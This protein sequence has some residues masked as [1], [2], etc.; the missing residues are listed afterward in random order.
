LIR[1]APLKS[2]DKPFAEEV[3][4]QIRSNYAYLNS[5]QALAPPAASP[6]SNNKQ[7]VR[8]AV[9][10]IN[11]SELLGVDREL[12]FSTDPASKLGFV[13]VVDRNTGDVIVQIPSQF[14][15]DLAQMLQN[16]N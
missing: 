5:L 1:K 12:R 9:N 11:E 3:R 7:A 14:I 2:A 16:H 15:L 8:E 10:T 13:Q 4:V 6:N